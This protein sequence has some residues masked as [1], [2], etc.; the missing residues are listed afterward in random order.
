ML[1]MPWGMGIRGSMFHQRTLSVA[2]LT[3]FTG[4]VV[5]AIFFNRKR[6]R[7]MGGYTESAALTEYKVFRRE[8][9]SALRNSLTLATYEG[10][11]VSWSME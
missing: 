6:L 8:G 7:W 3:V 2:A 10:D 4:W 5:R 9:I 11:G 1:S